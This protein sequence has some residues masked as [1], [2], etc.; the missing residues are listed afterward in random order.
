M[1]SLFVIDYNEFK[2]GFEALE[3]LLRA[4]EA[5]KYNNTLKKHV[6]EL[7]KLIEKCFSDYL[8]LVKNLAEDYKG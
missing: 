2:T 5:M 4:K 3:L 7:Q 8:W 1:L 6:D